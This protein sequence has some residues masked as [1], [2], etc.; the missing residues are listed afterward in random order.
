V[1]LIGDIKTLSFSLFQILAISFLISGSASFIIMIVF[2]KTTAR[3]TTRNDTTAVQAAHT[4]PTPRIGG[5]AIVLGLVVTSL[6]ILISDTLSVHVVLIFSALPVFV[7]GLAEDLG[8]LA[9]PRIRLLAAAVS[10]ALF[11]IL[12]GQWISKTDIPVLDLAM[13]WTPFAISLSLFLSVGI[14]HAFN[15]IDGLN[16]L[17]AITA[18]GVALA[19][20]LIAHQAGLFEHSKFLLILTAAIAGFL[21]LNFPFGRIFLGD[22]GAYVL[23][24]L[25]VWASISILWNAPNVTPLA[26]LLIFLWPI[27]DTIMAILRRYSS[28][29]PITQPDRLHFHQLAMRA[30]EIVLLGRS[31]RKLANPLATILTLPFVILPMIAGVFFADDPSKAAIACAFFGVTFF[32]T[33]KVGMWLAPKLRRSYRFPSKGAVGVAQSD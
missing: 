15:L 6:I 23:G 28:G 30:V 20:S 7:V 31:N 8:R 18:M 1:E 32:I 26:V 2:S 4:R 33:Y 22:A 25:L 16:G 11:I 29:K 27:A 5:L 10:G 19:L 12:I 17:A 3:L 9:S 24:H 13:L 14:S 21:V